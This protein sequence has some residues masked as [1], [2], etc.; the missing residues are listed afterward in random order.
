VTY[1]D[2][3][4]GAV[5]YADPIFAAGGGLN[6]LAA[7]QRATNVA[8]RRKGGATAMPRSL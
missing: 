8:S 5:D 3:I 4:G 1:A 2:A 6:G 7:D